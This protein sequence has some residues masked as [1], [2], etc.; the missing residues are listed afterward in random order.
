VDVLGARAAGLAAVLLDRSGTAPPQESEVI[1]SL[2]ELPPLLV[3]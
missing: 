2:A 1:R 3:P